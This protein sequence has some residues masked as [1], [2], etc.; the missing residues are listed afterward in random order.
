GRGGLPQR[1]LAARVGVSMRTVENWEAGINYPS[2]QALQALIA[3]LLEAG[4]LNVGRELEEVRQ[5]WAAV[6]RDAPRM[7]T[8]FDE[9]WLAEF[10][11][12]RTAPDA[13]QAAR[14][15]VP[16][17]HVVSAAEDGAVDRR[18]DWGESPDVLGF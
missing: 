5:L 15:L 3:A 17:A 2:A 10:L 13:A 8:P 6:L 18:Q 14:E 7:R 12:E 16:G 4:G 1:E 11:V 9:V